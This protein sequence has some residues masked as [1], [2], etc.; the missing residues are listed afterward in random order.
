MT[1]PDTPN[2]NQI[3]FHRNSGS[4]AAIIFIHG[5]S[6]KASGTWGSFAETL[7]A[8]PRLGAWDLIS[9]GYSSGLR[10][11]LAGIW[12]AD[13]SLQTVAD[14]FSTMCKL[15]SLSQYKTLALFA[16]SMGGLVVQR[17]LL[18]D[19]D[20]RSRVSRVM[21]FGT[22]SGG[23][24]KARL[25]QRLKRQFR[26][27][28]KGGQ[29]VTDL[30]IQW[31]Q[32]F[33]QNPPF[34]FHAIAGETDEFVP[35]DSSLAP[36]PVDFRSVVPGNHLEIVKANDADHP[37]VQFVISQITGD[38]MAGSEWN[39]ARVAIQAGEFQRAIEMLEPHQADLDDG[40]VVELAIALEKCGRQADA[41]TLLTS[42]ART[43]TDSMGVLAGRLKRRWMRERRQN[44]ADRALELYREAYKQATTANHAAQAFYHAINVA[45]MQ[46]AYKGDIDES[47]NWAVTALRHTKEAAKSE[48]S[49]DHWRLATE[50][51]AE[52]LLGNFDK[53]LVLY[54]RAFNTTNKPWEWD[55]MFSQA[56]E[57]ARQLGEQGLAQKLSDIFNQPLL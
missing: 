17:A 48:R 32:K 40:A 15:P 10:I 55:S 11:D 38:A 9:I 50:A 19:A 41:I 33:G 35:Y 31:D 23:L 44:D 3:V 34:K 56:T 1:G 49:T 20:L 8:E 24:G 53:G 5:F 52:L 4:G 21:L 54:N 6:G 25:V 28:A 37:S 26:D 39:S 46:L 36:F 2:Q 27:M 51:E 13:P 18:D 45:F 43:T 57:I 47:E 30:R 22:P 42:R 16:H 29:F 14:Y 12:S 7:S